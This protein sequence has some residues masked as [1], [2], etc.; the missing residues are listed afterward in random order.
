MAKVNYLSH[1][2]AFYSSN[3]I[4]PLAFHVNQ[5]S[6]LCALLNIL[7]YMNDREAAK[8]AFGAAMLRVNR[9]WIYKVRARKHY[10]MECE[11]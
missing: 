9:N 3:L 10:L 1:F 2:F 8:R 5:S 4:F 11:G 6:F 7:G